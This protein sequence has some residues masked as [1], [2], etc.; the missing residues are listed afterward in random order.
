MIRIVFH[1]FIARFNPWL[2]SRLFSS[3]VC[4]SPKIKLIN[5]LQ[6]QIKPL[7]TPS[8]HQLKQYLFKSHS[9]LALRLKASRATLKCKANTATRKLKSIPDGPMLYDLSFTV[10]VDVFTDRSRGQSWLVTPVRS[11]LL[12]VESQAAYA[13]DDLPRTHLMG[14]KGGV[15]RCTFRYSPLED[16]L[17][18]EVSGLWR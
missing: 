12:R 8:S 9:N 13:N 18:S 4:D 1:I 11:Q 7:V 17:G 15:A 5:N 14:R 16:C 3:Q 2:S 10:R 6:M